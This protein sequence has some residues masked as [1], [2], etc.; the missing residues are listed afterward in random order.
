MNR[1]TRMTVFIALVVFAFVF[2]LVRDNLTMF[3]T[4]FVPMAIAMALID[5]WKAGSLP[6]REEG[7]TGSGGGSPPRND[8]GADWSQDGGR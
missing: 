2:A 6:R 1:W 8:S 3:F 5:R 7:S 4:I